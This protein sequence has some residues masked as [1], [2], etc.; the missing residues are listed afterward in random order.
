MKKI[1]LLLLISQLA[2]AQT[3]PEP[4]LRSILLEQLKTTHTDK[5]WFVPVNIALQ[6]LT[7]EQANWTDGKGNHSI[8][9]LAHHLLFWNGRVL[10][11]FK[12]QDVA[13][14]DGD[15]D[16][17]FTNFDKKSWEDVVKRL[18]DVL[19]DLEKFVETANEAKLKEKYSTIAHIG[20]H[21]AYHTGQ[22]IYIRKLQG[23]WEADRGV[24]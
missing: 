15:N 24:K 13:K 18:D 5:D 22:I 6:G 2:M 8:G 19:A 3:K 12:G 17:T 11:S 23:S 7:A 4:T 16:K 20:T 14:F 1:F 21:N 9:Q 10:A